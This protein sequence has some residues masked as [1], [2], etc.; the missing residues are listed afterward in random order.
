MISFRCSANREKLMF[1]IVNSFLKNSRL[2]FNPTLFLNCCGFLDTFRFLRS[3]IMGF[4]TFRNI[5]IH[6]TKRIARKNCQIG[7]S[8]VKVSSPSDDVS[9]QRKSIHCSCL[10][11]KTQ[12][13]FREY[14]C[15]VFVYNFPAILFQSPSLPSDHLLTPT[16]RQQ[17]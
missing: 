9:Q 7:I 6:I 8:E 11:E 16:S 2:D 17:L 3:T 15:C 12:A 14:F 5:A 1:P 4:P 13:A 10:G